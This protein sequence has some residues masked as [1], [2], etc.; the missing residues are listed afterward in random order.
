VN[1]TTEHMSDHFVKYHLND[2]GQLPIPVA[3]VLHHFTSPDDGLF[4]DHPFGLW[5]TVLYG[6]Y[7]EETVDRSAVR[8]GVWDVTRQRRREHE[9]FHVPARHIHRIVEL[10][11]GECVTV[12]VYGP[13]EREVWL[14]RCKDGDVQRCPAQAA[15]G[16]A[17]WPWE[18]LASG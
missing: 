8:L 12:A 1:I 10:P 14:W 15:W 7:V 5:C 16:P 4:H 3:P 2:R 11:K 18:A 17:P 6:G 9:T 13:L